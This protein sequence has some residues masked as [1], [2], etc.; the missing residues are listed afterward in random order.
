MSKQYLT[1]HTLDAAHPTDIFSLAVTPTQIISASGSSSLQIHSTTTLDFPHVQT[2]PK[3]HKLGC[4]HVA[5]SANGKK[6]ASVGF[7]GQVKVWA[8]DEKN[9]TWGL[10]AELVGANFLA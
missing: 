4:H 3:A 9:E 2:L 5:T 8:V 10:E 6:A 7:E 1:T